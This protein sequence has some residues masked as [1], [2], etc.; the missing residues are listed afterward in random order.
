M[1]VYI[2]KHQKNKQLNH[3]QKKT[4]AAI[5]FLT[6]Y[7]KIDFSYYGLIHLYRNLYPLW[8]VFYFDLH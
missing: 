7:K 3:I 6:G 5:Y 2:K 1:T 8:M 4:D